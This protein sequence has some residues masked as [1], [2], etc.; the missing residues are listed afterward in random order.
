MRVSVRGK[1]YDSVEEAAKANNVAVASVYCAL[2]RGN[3]ERLGLGVDYEARKTKGGK[4]PKPV[5]VCGIKF[6]SMAELAR[7]IG[8]EPKKLRQSLRRGNTAK[9]RIVRAVMK[10]VAERENAAMKEQSR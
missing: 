2:T 9:M 7:A 8:R 4:P 3:I 10:L 6:E 1:T 5:S